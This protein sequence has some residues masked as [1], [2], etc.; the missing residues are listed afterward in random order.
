MLF[1]SPP[2]AP[3][4]PSSACSP[5][6]PASSQVLVLTQ[7]YFSDQPV[8]TWQ[9]TVMLLHDFYPWQS[10]FIQANKCSS[11]RTPKMIDNCIDQPSLDSKDYLRRRCFCLLSSLHL[12]KLDNFTVNNWFTIRQPTSRVQVKTLITLLSILNKSLKLYYQ[13]RDISFAKPHSGNTR[14]FLF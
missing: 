6:A 3:S 12:V 11:R 13:H 8:N 2:T 10:F 14:A 1:V 9:Q 5:P 7:S 4:S